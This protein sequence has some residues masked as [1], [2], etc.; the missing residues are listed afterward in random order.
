LPLRSLRRACTRGNRRRTRYGAEDGARIAAVAHRA[1]HR[2]RVDRERA[3]TEFT[4][5]RPTEGSACHHHSESHTARHWRS[6]PERCGQRYR[7]GRRQAG[8]KR[9]RNAL[10]L[11]AGATVER[12]ARNTKLSGGLC[13]AHYFSPADPPDMAARILIVEDEMLIAF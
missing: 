7:Q 1:G 4:E 8:T 6:A 13:R 5:A 12:P 2:T 10:D 11:H 9:P 3:R